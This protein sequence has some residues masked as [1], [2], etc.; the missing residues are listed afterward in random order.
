MIGVE[1]FSGPGGMGLGAK[2]AGVEVALAV[3]KNI[4]AAQTYLK[5]HTEAT[6]VTDDI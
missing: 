4:Y 2:Y 6:V 1:I 3:E 5:N